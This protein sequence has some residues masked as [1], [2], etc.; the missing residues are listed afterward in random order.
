[1]IFGNLSQ[2]F[3]G[4]QNIYEAVNSNFSPIQQPQY[5]NTK[6]PGKLAKILYTLSHYGMNWSD[7]ITKNMNAIPADKLLQPKDDVVMQANLF[8]G[9]MDNWKKK[10][11]E[12][13]P[14]KE[15]TLEQKRE[16]LRKMAANP[17]LE[18][19][20][21][22]LANEAIVYDED[23]VY[24]GEPY[25]E[26]AILQQLNE[27]HIEEIQNAVDAAFYKMYMLLNWKN[28]AW[29]EFKRWLI[30]GVVSYEIVYDD[31]EN[32][33]SI[34]GIVAVDPA[35]LTRVI[36]N[37]VE[38][39]IQFKDVIGQERKLLSSQIIYIK[40]EDSGVLERQSY[41]ERL[42]RPFNI[43]RIIEQ[44]QIIWTVTQSSFKTIFTIPVAGMNKAKG[45][46]T[47]NSAM[48]RYKEDIDFNT[49]TG[50]LQVNGRVNLPFNKEY[51]M[52]ENENG[53]PEIET[54]ADQGP[55]LQD[56]DQLKY[57]LSKLYKMSKIPENRF[58][59]EAQATWFGSDPTQTLRDEINF[60]RFVNRLRNVFAQIIIKPIQI[61]ISLSIPE[62]KNDKRVLDAIILRYN[63]YNQFEEMMNIEI[64]TKRMEFISTLREAF[65]STDAEG[66]EE[67]YFSDKFLIMRYLKMSDSDLE[68]NE[69]CKLEEKQAKGDEESDEEGEDDM[70]GDEEMSGDM[71]SE[72]MGG[73][74]SGMESDET[75]GGD[76]EMMGDVQPDNTADTGGEM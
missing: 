52:P 67:R 16:V 23:E 20:L 43:Y 1:M 60:G 36:E 5:G 38:Y 29:D 8:G 30:D 19:I 4:E 63:S 39:W 44:A 46:Q 50:E 62:L 24:I 48:A 14:F 72:D 35:T 11:E 2:V 58:D 68:W 27:Q 51:W 55:S 7:D 34:I 28:K 3:E 45:M 69:K 15:K 66:N 61:Q 12:D 65:M 37:G 71:G 59:K 75:G 9:M 42:I 40:Y 6:G 21:D 53:K 17:E 74:D 56:S 64:D 10:P 26:P 32:P 47:L 18:D 76:S 25:I 73:E 49:E 70:G 13:K 31:I 54:L 22:I 41:L 57:F 33:H